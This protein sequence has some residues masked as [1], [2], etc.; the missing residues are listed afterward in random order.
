MW[1][2]AIA[3]H[4]KPYFAEASMLLA[5]NAVDSCIG[6]GCDFSA[7]VDLPQKQ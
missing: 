2:L 7:A 3:V 6:F 5:Q 4:G 1:L